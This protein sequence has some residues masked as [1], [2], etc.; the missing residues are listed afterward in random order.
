[1]RRPAS[2]ISSGIFAVIW[3]SMNPGATAFTVTCCAAAN[4]ARPWT[5]PI[6]PAL[7]V[8][9]VALP[10]VAGDAGNRRHTDDTPARVQALAFQQRVA[11]LQRRL[12]VDRQ[13][14]TPRRFGHLGDGLVAGDPGVM[15]HHVKGAGL[16]DMG[17]QQRGRICCGNVQWQRRATDAGGGMLQRVLGLGH[18]HAHH[19]G[20]AR[21]NTWAI[22]KP[23][24]RE[25]PVTSARR[26]AKGVS[27]L[28]VTGPSSGFPGAPLAPTHRPNDA[29]ERSAGCCPWRLRPPARRRSI[30]R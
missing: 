16:A 30:A 12:Q 11:Q 28:T 10:E 15:H 2:R 14:I 18:I 7:E 3:V 13:H 24:P 29:T 17:L 27:Q 22:A 20:A 26:P 19:M 21:A 1:M 9:V 8:G 25:A 6:T 4:G 23:M 5:R